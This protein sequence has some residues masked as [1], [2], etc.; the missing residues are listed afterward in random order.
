MSAS[1]ARRGRLLVEPVDRHDREE[2]VDGPDVG[3]R[4]EHREV[5]EVGVGERLLEALELLGHLAACSRTICRI[6]WQM[7]QKMSSATTRSVSDRWPSVNSSAPLPCT[8]ARRGRPRGSSCGVTSLVGLEEVRAPR[9][10]VR[11]GELVGR[12]ADVELADAQDVEDQHR[13]GGRRP[14]AP[15][16]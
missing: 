4:L 13:R 16:R 12:L 11:R 1:T 5:A 3:Q 9:G 6:F 7:P 15:T 8:R 10:G 2:L 14:R